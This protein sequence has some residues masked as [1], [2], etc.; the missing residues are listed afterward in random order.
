MSIE[1][2]EKPELDFEKGEAV[3]ARDIE[4]NAAQ[5]SDAAKF[6]DE[7]FVAKDGSAWNVRTY[8]NGDNEMLRVFD[9]TQGVPSERPTM[10]PAYANLT[11][12]RGDD[13]VIAR[14]RLNDIYVPAEQRELG[15]GSHLLNSA[16]QN[17]VDHGA[18]E[19][20][21]SAPSEVEVRN[22]YEY[23]GYAFRSGTFGEEV[24]KALE[25]SD[26]H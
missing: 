23:R 2:A 3:I 19:I 1:P 10:T 9:E 12:E 24:F 17:A 5:Q 22:W 13:G 11:H 25:N 4:R 6:D 21:G 16:E 14:T 15:I 20:Y 26:G 8:H 7:S 18:H